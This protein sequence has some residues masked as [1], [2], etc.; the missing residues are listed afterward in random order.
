MIRKTTLFGWLSYLFG[1]DYNFAV[2]IGEFM[3]FIQQIFR[4][5]VNFY[6]FRIELFW[7]R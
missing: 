1:N 4:I 7:D 6:G 2:F 3:I 5:D